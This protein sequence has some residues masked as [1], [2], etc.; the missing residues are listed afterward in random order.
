VR[1]LRRHT[2][3][4]PCPDPPAHLQPRPPRRCGVRD[5]ENRA[6]QAV[7]D[8]ADGHVRRGAPLHAADPV[9]PPPHAAGEEAVDHVVLWWAG[10]GG[11]GA[12]PGGAGGAGWGGVGAGWGRGGAGWGGAGWGRGGVGRGGVGRGGAGW[13]VQ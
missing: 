3:V 10:R 8:T 12:G 2:C 1:L 7:A 13:G 6:E 5:G 9:A 4:L 11:G